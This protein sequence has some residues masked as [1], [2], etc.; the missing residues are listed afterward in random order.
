MSVRGERWDR[1]RFAY[2][3]DRDRGRNDDDRYYMRGGQGR[4]ERGDPRRS[5]DD[6]INVRARSSQYDYEPRY[7]RERDS[8]A[9]AGRE[10][11]R[12]MTMERE[13]ERDYRSPSP[14][15]PSFLRRQ[16]S[17]DTFDRRPLHR[18]YEREEYGP[19][20]RRDD[21]RAPPYTDIP[22]PPSRGLPPPRQSRER[23]HYEDLDDLP[24]EHIHERE[25]VRSRER[26][27]RS[28]DRSRESRATKVSRSRTVRSSS[29]TSKTTSRSSSSSGGTTIISEYP[30]KGKTRVPA[31][32]VSKRALIDLGY[33]FI[34]EVRSYSRI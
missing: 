26:R 13:R 31:R 20:A 29:K 16:S 24:P 23:I 25:V 34:E 3:R 9:G 21:Y 5:Y 7:E 4:N 22:L 2:E 17:L 14:R 12:G 6:D 11:D 15:R 33:P 1:D 18:F 10:P 32:L 27:D 28:R 30:K 19:P 8:A